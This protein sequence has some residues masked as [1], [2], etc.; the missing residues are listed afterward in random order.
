VTVEQPELSQAFIA[1]IDQWLDRVA[2][3]DDGSGG[4]ESFDEGPGMGSGDGSGIADGDQQG[5]A[6]EKNDDGGEHL[7]SD[8]GGPVGAPTGG[9]VTD[10]GRSAETELPSQPADQQRAW[11]DL[12]ANLA[13]QAAREEAVRL[14]KQA[15]VKTFVARVLGQKTDE[16]AWRIGADG[17]EDVAWR[18]RKLGDA[19]SVLHAVPVGER[20]SDIDHVVVGP[21]GVYTLNTKHHPNGKVWVAERT[22]MVNGTKTNYL[23]SSRFEASRASQRL[24]AACGV[25]VA[26]EPVIVV[27]A[28]ELT[29][30]AQPS[31]VHVVGRRHIVDWLLARPQVLDDGMVTRIYDQ[32]RRNTTWL[33]S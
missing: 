17:E 20:G 24:G 29:I 1:A 21:G 10:G 23:R 13:G 27:I 33:G 2:R 4:G 18:L 26:V 9:P 7:G 5:H 15:P 28:K 14:R 30:K 16:R 12:G 8:A 25:E 22:L 11:R 32:A 6:S 31:D 3:P 19:W